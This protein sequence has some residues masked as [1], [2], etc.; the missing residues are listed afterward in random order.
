MELELKGEP[1][2]RQGTGRRSEMASSDGPAGLAGIVGAQGARV[3]AIIL[4]LPAPSGE[5]GNPARVPVRF[6]SEY[7]EDPGNHPKTLP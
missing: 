1:S 7:P 4:G 6:I 5:T 3:D 2:P